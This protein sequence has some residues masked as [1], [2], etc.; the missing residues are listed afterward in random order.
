MQNPK[1]DIDLLSYKDRLRISQKDGITYVYDVIRKKNLIMQPEEFVRQLIIH[2]FLEENLFPKS[3]IAVEKKITVDGLEKRF[4]VLIFDKLGQPYLL[5]ECKSF[6]IKINESV[7]HQISN[8]NQKLKCPFLLVSNGK[9]TY[10]CE[11]D[12]SKGICNYKT[13]IE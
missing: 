2:Y 5:V 10:Y 6:D 8:Y 13:K 9:D 4:D 12:Y 7:M 3:R 11:V 1:L